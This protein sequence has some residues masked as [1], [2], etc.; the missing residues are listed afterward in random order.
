MIVFPGTVVVTVSV[1]VLTSLLVI[2]IV[3]LYPGKVIVWPGAVLV[4]VS[5]SVFVL[6]G[7]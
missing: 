3:A 4:I 2:V 7:Q 5:V 6:V 1:F